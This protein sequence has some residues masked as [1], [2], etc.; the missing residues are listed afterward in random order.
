MKEEEKKLILDG[1]QCGKKY[2]LGADPP[3]FE[4]HWA[5]RCFSLIYLSALVLCISICGSPSRRLYLLVPLP[6]YLPVHS[7]F[8][9]LSSRPDLSLHFFCFSL[10]SRIRRRHCYTLKQSRL[11]LLLGTPLPEETSTC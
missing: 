3:A 6:I 10:L 2:N 5:T 8:L 7:L 9:S 4:L 11:F 1:T